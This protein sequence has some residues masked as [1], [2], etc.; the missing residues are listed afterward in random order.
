MARTQRRRRS[1]PEEERPQQRQ[2]P[3]P[4]NQDAMRA[5]A[6]ER[7][8][9]PFITRAWHADGTEYTDDEYEAAGID[10]PS[11]E[12]KEWLNLSLEERLARIERE[13]NTVEKD[14]EE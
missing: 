6:R 1:Q 8:G 3:E 4:D 13:A 7:L 12:Q 10:P 11:S 2:R 9:G 14:D 5:A